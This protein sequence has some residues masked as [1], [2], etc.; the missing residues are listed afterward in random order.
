VASKKLKVTLTKSLIGLSP[1][2]E[3]TVKALGLRRIRQQVTHEDTA[4]VRGMIAK[5]PHVLEVEAHEA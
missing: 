2:Q 1:K 3:S 4:T 5:V